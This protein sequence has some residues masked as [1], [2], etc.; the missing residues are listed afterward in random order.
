MTSL[1]DFLTHLASLNIRLMPDGNQ[2][3]YSAPR[4]AVTP[5][6][7]EQ[8]SARKSEILEFLR[9]TG[10]RPGSHEA[11]VRRC[12]REG[13]IPLSFAQQRLWFLDQFEPGNAYYNL[14]WALHLRGH[15]RVPVLEQSLNEIV[16]RHEVLRTTFSLREDGTPIQIIHPYSAAK[17]RVN[18]LQTLPELTQMREVRKAAAQEIQLPFDLEKGPLLRPP[19]FRLSNE[20]H[21]LLLVM[22]HIVTDG[23]SMG[24]F[25]R[26]LT[27]IYQSFS[28]GTPASLPEL[29]VQYADFAVWQREWLRGKHLEKHLLY[30]KEQ[31]AGAPPVLE[32]PSDRPRPAKLTYRGSAEHFHI[33]PDVTEKLSALS[34]QKGVS[35]FMTLFAAF[36][37]LLFRYTGQK[38]M[39]I[40]STTAGRNHKAI[41]NLIGFFVNNLVLRSDMSGDPCFS[42]LLTSVRQVTLDAYAHQ[43]MP[44]EQLVD[45][46][47]AERNLSHTPLFQ[48]MFVWR[49]F[50][51]ENLQLP[52]LHVNLLETETFTALYDLNLLMMKT[53]TGMA[54]TLEYSTDLFDRSTISRMIG[55]FQTLLEGVAEEPDHKISE[56]PVLTRAERVQLLEEFNDTQAAYPGN[57]TISDLF[58]EQA[59]ETPDNIAVVFKETR[60]KYWE[61]NKQSNG[62]AWYLKETHDVRPGEFIA[63]ILDRTEQMISVLLGILKAGAAYV[64]IDP[65]Y[66]HE[67][68]RYILEDSGCRIILT[69][70]E[71]ESLVSEQLCDTT[72]E[73]KKVINIRT[74]D[75]G[76]TEDLPSISAPDNPAYVIYTSGSTGQPK[77]CVITHR[78][79]V[80]LMKNDRFHFEFGPDDVWVVAHSFCFDF[81][82]W[83]M[84]GALLYG[85]K[86]IVATHEDVQD[87]QLFLQL[88]RKHRVSLLNQTPAAFYNLIEAE[89][90]EA[91]HD[92][93][94]HLRYVIFGGDKL[95]PIYLQS[96]A[97]RYP[98][99][100]IRL[101]NMYGITETTVHVTYGLLSREHIFEPGGASPIGI[102]LPET[103]VYV[104]DE[105]MNLQPVGVPGELYV[106]GTGVSQGYLNRDALT[107]R[108]FVKDPFKPGD[109]L[110]R[111]GDVGRWIND[112]TLEFFGRN[113]DQ[114]QIRGY[115]VELGEIET[116]LCAHEA[117]EKA[118]IIARDGKSGVKE[119]AAYFT[120]AGHA[121]HGP[122]ISEIREHLRKTLPDYMIPSY[123]IPLEAF[124]LTSNKKVDRGSLPDP[125]GFRTGSD[126]DYVT[127]GTR[128]EHHITE[129][130]KDVIG[131]RHIGIHDNFFDIGGHSMLMVRIRN[132]LQKLFDQEISIVE[133]FKYPTIHT[134]A[135]YL[136]RKSDESSSEQGQERARTR[137]TRSTSVNRQRQSRLKHREKAEG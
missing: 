6:L 53:D 59:E 18:D 88:I 85:G 19:L 98:L 24:I 113:D 72:R 66:P 128:A 27:A 97:E 57:K 56:L 105:Q 95:N 106:G 16:R 127:P 39:V 50:P 60:L 4:D 101:V 43:D 110:Y 70:T 20:T 135:A 79:V 134:L 9:K 103:R 29:S 28:Q 34:R 38:D 15:L 90:D 114:V 65:C 48:V 132:R 92:L 126:S 96:W 7:R 23:W 71:Y 100:T 44:F 86:V 41:E 2:L 73:S 1:E 99:E 108:R 69:E 131:V 31:L 36:N 25:I 62:L 76:K 78:N 102:P 89:A 54:A 116:C 136:T 130:W 87:P 83:E 14:L 49:N 93:D 111:T 32:L 30:W 10:L 51:F 33:S 52:D 17:V 115:R 67:R 91:Q 74:I 137:R 117:V 11:P 55:H 45:A 109:T 13:D 123:F 119:L 26:E 122:N 120:R 94:D 58:E 40:G 63:V 121:E 125:E 47:G 82:V 118:V 3:R 8:L 104:C 112:G 129:V 46:L 133:M 84:Y 64:P 61:L 124:P 81:S 68:I 37:T 5:E 77:G 22:H 35:L 21:V 107:A 42:E 75:A 80:R 12:S